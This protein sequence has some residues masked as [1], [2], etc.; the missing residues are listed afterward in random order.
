M[1][2]VYR[3]LERHFHYVLHHS[4]V[5][6]PPRFLTCSVHNDREWQLVPHNL[7]CLYRRPTMRKLYNIVSYEIISSTMAYKAHVRG[8]PSELASLFETFSDARSCERVT[9]QDRVL[10]PPGTPTTTGQR[11]FGYRAVSLLNRLPVEARTLNLPSFKRAARSL[12]VQ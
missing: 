3:S 8:E 5:Q 11:S 6:H 12:L 9:R 1:M 2:V 4:L 7:I 10:R